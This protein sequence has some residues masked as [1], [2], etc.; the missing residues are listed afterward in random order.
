[1]TLDEIVF[2]DKSVLEKNLRRGLDE[3]RAHEWACLLTPLLNKAYAEGIETGY[4]I[5][6]TEKG[7]ETAASPNT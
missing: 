3:K 5:A 7:D 2:L 1:M 6:Q 4:E